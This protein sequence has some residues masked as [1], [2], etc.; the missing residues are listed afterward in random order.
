MSLLQKISKNC[1]QAEAILQICKEYEETSNKENELQSNNN[2]NN[3]PNSSFS[4]FS[5]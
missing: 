5:K 3:D 2:K 1:E 4:I